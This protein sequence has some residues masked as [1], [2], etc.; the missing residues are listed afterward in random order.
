MKGTLS[1]NLTTPIKVASA[2]GRC[3][4][5]AIWR[6]HWDAKRPRAPDFGVSASE[7][8]TGQAKYRPCKKVHIQMAEKAQEDTVMPGGQAVARMQG[9]TPSPDLENTA[10]ELAV[11]NNDAEA[12]VY[13]WN[14]WVCYL[15]G[16]TS[17]ESSHL[18]ALEL[19]R[20]VI[21]R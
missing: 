10:T 5:D 1:R 8:D 19:L 15:L 20:H 17:L 2:L 11:K 4:Q 16:V 14:D 13:L 12:P 21:L 18:Q 9:Y 3:I 7:D 6:I